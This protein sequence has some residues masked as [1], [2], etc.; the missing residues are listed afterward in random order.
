V[1]DEIYD[2]IV[3]GSGAGG[4]PVASNLALAGYEVLVLEA[5]ED[6]DGY[7]YRVPCFH[8]LASEDPAMSWDFFVRHYADQAKQQADTKYVP[9]KDGI[10][11]PRAG[12]LGGCT[13]HNAMITVYPQN[14]DWD[15][16]QALTGDASWAAEHMRIYF[17]RLEHCDYIPGFERFKQAIWGMLHGQG[18]NPSKHGYSG[19]LHTQTADPKM[20]FKDT[21]LLRVVTLAAVTGL[22]KHLGGLGLDLST[23]FDPND[24]RTVISKGREGVGMTPLATHTG[25]RNSVRERLLD[26]VKATNG[27][28]KIQMGALASKVLFEGTRAVGVEYLSGSKLYRASTNPSTDAA[29]T[30]VTV[31]ARYEVILSGGAFNS[32]QLLMLSGIGDPDELRS[33][34][35]TPLVNRP[36]VGKNMQDRY[37][38]GVIS[39]MAKPFALLKGATFLL[40][41]GT[42]TDDDPALTEWSAGKG[43]VYCS[44]GAAIAVTKRSRPDKVDPD[45]FIF[46]LPSKFKGYYPGY[47]SALAHYQD[48]FTWAILKAHTNNTA[49]EVKLRSADPRDTPAINFHYF[50][51]GN[52]TSGD[53]LN[54]V[55]QGVKFARE[56]N[57]EISK[58]VGMTEQWPGPGISSDEDIAAF[59]QREAWGHHAS[60]TNPI[61]LADDP[62]AVLDSRFRVHGTTGLRVV[63]ASVFPRI[64]GYFIVSAVYMIAEKASDVILE[65]T[66]AAKASGGVA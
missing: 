25:C 35:I 64:P 47:S 52:D 60:C 38:V 62:K 27:K 53:D 34:G 15:H 14:S 40:P 29:P 36:G 5:G 23:L 39:Q 24:W 56:M 18:T 48:M 20:I 45:L 10:F 54:A 37:E 16:L 26:T 4:G 11:Y 12:T 8:P 63:D 66:K 19:W 58:T 2:F 7:T 41:D 21:E 9:E 32:P 13:A 44:N 43:G 1:A 22:A 28:L 31:Q 61:G 17:E 3:V 30:K 33:F 6:C 59:I 49:G 57:Y 46:G 50:S 55:V 65:D 42:T 51:E